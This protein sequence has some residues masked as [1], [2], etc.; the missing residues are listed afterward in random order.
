MDWISIMGIA[1]A[2]AMDAFAVALAAG[3]VLNPITGRHLFRLGFHFG[4]FQALMPIAGWLLGL[5]VQKWIT[6]YDHWI[7]FG[8][9]AYVG[10]RMIV[11]AFDD[12]EDGDPADPTRGLTMVMLSIATSIDAFAVGLSLAML[13]VSVWVPSVVIGLVAGVLTVT[14]MLLGRKLGDNWGK[15]V[16]VCGGVVL[17]LIGLKILLEHTLLK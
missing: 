16:E 13:G 2:L 15:R 14:G 11:E 4:L 1:V 6:S 12:E 5:T 9:L 8:L 7:A 17:C 10:G 3:A